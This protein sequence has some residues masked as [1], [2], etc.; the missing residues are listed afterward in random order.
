MWNTAKNDGKSNRR[1]KYNKK[2]IWETPTQQ[3]G[4]IISLKGFSQNPSHP[5]PWCP[6]WSPSGFRF[7]TDAPL[8]QPFSLT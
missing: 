8:C 3:E 6:S 4:T 2:P 7:P 5:P 1:R